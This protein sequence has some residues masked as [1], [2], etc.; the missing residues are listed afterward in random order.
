MIVG[1]GGHSRVLIDCLRLI[2]REIL[3]CAEIAP[4]L[5]GQTLDG[6]LIEGSDELILKLNP[7]EVQL[8]NG[9]GSVAKP[10]KRQVIY[11]RFVEFGFSFTGVI[12]PSATI[13]KSATI[14]NGV[15]IMAQ[16]VLQPGVAVGSNTLINTGATV[17]HDCH[18][19]SHC[20]I[21]PRVALSGEVVVGNC[22]HIGTGASVIQGISV[23]SG[24][25]VGAGATVVNDLADN[26]SAVGVPAKPIS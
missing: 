5:H 3:F 18:V 6:V 10:T 17:D 21:A 23:G 4:E 8:V 16:V 13:A 7:D 11:E 12:H 14:G 26:T 15:Q 19:H 20:H 2:G 1:S 9:M 24:C 25:V 22:S